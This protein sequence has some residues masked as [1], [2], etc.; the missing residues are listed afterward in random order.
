MEAALVRD[1]VELWRL[2]REHPEWTKPQFAEWLNRSLSW[3]KK[4]LRRFK[5]TPPET[6]RR[7]FSAGHGPRSTPGE[8]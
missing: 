3:V 7:C 4:W 6:H 1:R 2:S 5:E 8:K